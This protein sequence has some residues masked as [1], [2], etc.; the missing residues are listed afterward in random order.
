M[1]RWHGTRFASIILPL[2]GVWTQSNQSSSKLGLSLPSVLGLVIVG[3][4]LSRLNLD[5]AQEFLQLSAS[6]EGDGDTY[7][8]VRCICLLSTNTHTD[9]GAGCISRGSR[10]SAIR[11]N[12]QCSSSQRRTYAPCDSK[13]VDCAH[14]RILTF[15]V[16]I[17]MIP[18]TPP[19]AVS[20][21]CRNIVPAIVGSLVD[22]HNAS[23][24]SSTQTSTKGWGRRSPASVTMLPREQ[25]MYL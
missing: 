14:Q 9:F 18:V 3:C 11:Y 5:V 23:L 20:W 22:A 12:V 25:A 15:K 19:I 16:Q 13:P 17:L 2:R 1:G 21:M 6:H 7:T 10:C 24:P 8:M 4:L